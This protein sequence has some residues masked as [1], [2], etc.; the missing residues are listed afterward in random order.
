MFSNRRLF[1]RV[2]CR[3]AASVMLAS[4]L[5]SAPAAAASGWSVQRIP[6]PVG[7]NARL[8]GVSCDPTGDCM[9]VGAVGLRPQRSFAERWNGSSWSLQR[10]TSPQ[11]SQLVAVS[12]PSTR[13][14]VAVGSV[15]TPLSTFPL[16]ERWNGSKWSLEPTPYQGAGM[17]DSVSCISPGA[18][19]AVGISSAPAA[20]NQAPL[21]ERWN[22]SR[23]SIEKIANPVAQNGDAFSGVSCAAPRVCIAVGSTPDNALVERWNGAWTIQSTPGSPGNGYYGFTGVSCWSTT[24]C[25]AVGGYASS[26]GTAAL[27]KLVGGTSDH[28]FQFGAYPGDT[29]FLAVSCTS[30]TACAAVEATDDPMSSAIEQWNGVKWSIQPTP[31]SQNAHLLGLSCTARSGCVAVGSM[32][33]PRNS[34]VPLIEQQS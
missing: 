15:L 8:T 33:G 28:P 18:C 12:C 31:R 1:R 6:T 32:H 9:A 24:A 10:I 4:W 20:G 30:N 13:D 19:T 7:A 2:T 34:E 27:G 25:E 29:E 5:V 3:A 14:C 21:A 16:A 17:L 23:W 26:G 22:G 11:G